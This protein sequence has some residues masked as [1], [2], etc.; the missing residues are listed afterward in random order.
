LQEG[1][2]AVF[3]FFWNFNL[4]I[5]QL[6]GHLG[7][8]SIRLEKVETGRASSEVPVQLLLGLRFQTLLQVIH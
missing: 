2:E 6:L 8:G 1:L 5:L 3:Y 7:A 4:L